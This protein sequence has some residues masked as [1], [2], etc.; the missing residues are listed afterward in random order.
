MASVVELESK[1]LECHICLET[2]RRPK[3]I[4]CLHSFCEQCLN[5]YISN[6]RELHGARFPCPVCKQLVDC[7]DPS[8]PRGQWASS[9]KGSFFLND[10]ADCLKAT[11]TPPL[12]SPCSVCQRQNAVNFCLDCDHKLCEYC[13]SVHGRI[14][15][16][17][18]HEV[19]DYSHSHSPR[20]HRRR[21]RFCQT[22]K[23]RVLDLYCPECSTPLCQMCHLTL[24]KLCNGVESMSDT[25]EQKR[26][27]LKELEGRTDYYINKLARINEALNRNL[28]AANMGRVSDAER[29]KEF[30]IKAMHAL[31]KK[32][33]EL[34]AELEKIYENHCKALVEGKR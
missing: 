3:T 2:Y 4:P 7:P 1:F 24:H 15:T 19:V 17:S 10:L 5:D 16:S 20:V 27:W 29:L 32:Q 6:C 12:T 28:E 8:L 9:F 11:I 31:R 14:P 26:V 34:L 25:A 33:D 21:R 13:S 23:D 22:H 30:F 18:N